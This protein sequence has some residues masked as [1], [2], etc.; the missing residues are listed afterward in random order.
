[1][2]KS[3][4][5]SPPPRPEAH[6]VNG[7]PDMR[8][9]F[10]TNGAAMA[11][12]IKASEAMLEGMAEMNREVMDFASDR[13]RKSWQTSESLMGCQDPAQ[14]FGVQCE[15]ARV[16]TQAY[17]EEATRLMA[18]AAKMSDQCLHSMETQANDAG[19]ARVKTP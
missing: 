4:N 14:A 10:E 15:H 16:A 12:A 6:P 7:M 8:A 2:A 11:A 13:L 5:A 17:L 1:M 18:L 19:A 9:V 3:R